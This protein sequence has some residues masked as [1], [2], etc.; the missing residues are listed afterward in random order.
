MQHVTACIPRNRAQ[1][2]ATIILGHMDIFLWHLVYSI[3]H[4]C[5]IINNDIYKIAQEKCHHTIDVW[6]AL[7]I[8]SIIIFFN[9]FA[10]FIFVIALIFFN[11][12]HD[13]NIAVD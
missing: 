6:Y 12:H 10:L 13:S 4:I 5:T 9:A 2:C 8:F 11:V 1:E 3:V 7:F